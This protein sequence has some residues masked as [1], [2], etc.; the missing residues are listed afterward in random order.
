MTGSGRAALY[1]LFD[2][3]GRLLYVG[4]TTDPHQRWKRHA[5]F[6]SWWGQVA[7][8]TVDWLP[9]WQE[10]LAAEKRAIQE[11]GPRFNGTHNHPVA[12]FVATEWQPITI[13]RGK[14]VALAERICQEIDAGRWRPGMKIP[15]CDELATATSI[16]PTTANLALRALQAEGRLKYLRG[17][18]IFVYDGVALERPN[19]RRPLPSQRSWIDP[20]PRKD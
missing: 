1:R 19:R 18:G 5:M 9:S 3:E 6:M 11:E 2:A 16:S 8:R 4:I 13:R 14:A 12:P 20:C 15:S 17:V 10:A 7:R